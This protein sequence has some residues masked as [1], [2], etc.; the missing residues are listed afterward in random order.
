MRLRGC[1]I[2][3]VPVLKVLEEKEQALSFGRCPVCSGE[4]VVMT[5]SYYRQDSGWRLQNGHNPGA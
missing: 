4:L 3:E 2:D 1:E 5:S